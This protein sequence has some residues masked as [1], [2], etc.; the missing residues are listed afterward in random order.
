MNNL[1]YYLISWWTVHKISLP[2][3]DELC[4][5]LAFAKGIAVVARSVRKADLSSPFKLMWF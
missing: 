5:L 1:I 2:M 4:C 3:A